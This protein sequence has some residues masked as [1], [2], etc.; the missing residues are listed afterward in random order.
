MPE[1]KV[2]ARYFA[3]YISSV[4]RNADDLS[5]KRCKRSDISSFVQLGVRKSESSDL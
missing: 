3:Q 5:K 2:L 1:T 4:R